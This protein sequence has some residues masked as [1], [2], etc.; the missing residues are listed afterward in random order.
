M[1]GV[2]SIRSAFRAARFWFDG[3]V[4]DVTEEQ[5]RFTP[6]GKAHSIAALATHVPQ[7][8]DFLINGMLQ[9][10]PTLWQSGG[11]EEKLGIPN[12]ANLQDGVRIDT[13]RCIEALRPYSSAVAA[14]T[15]AY[16]DSLTD[17]D[18]DRDVDMSAFGM[19]PMRLGD[20]LTTFSVGNTFAHTGEISAI[21]G[22]QGAQGY[23]F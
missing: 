10:K 8:E 16:L 19:E 7:A 17:Q 20:V 12:V 14:S 5:E 13:R 18:L 22:V 21:K 6:P 1:N 23:P 9:G 11:W 3:T 15:D 2:D 4:A